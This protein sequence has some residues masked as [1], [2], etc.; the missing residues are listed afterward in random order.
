M[1][2]TCYL[3]SSFAQILL[4]LSFGGQAKKLLSLFPALSNSW[5]NPAKREA[6][7]PENFALKNFHPAICPCISQANRSE[8]L[9]FYSGSEGRSVV[10]PT[11]GRIDHSERELHSFSCPNYSISEA[12]CKVKKGW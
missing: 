6:M 3:A 7:P 8:L 10:N 11:K 12:I 1:R 9:S 5:R 2:R 4:C